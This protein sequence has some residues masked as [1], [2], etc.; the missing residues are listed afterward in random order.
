[1]SEDAAAKRRLG[2]G[3]SA[4]LGDEE[5]D[6]SELDKVRATKSVP[7]EFVEAGRFQPRRNF[8]AAE[9]AS[10]TASVREKGILQPILVRRHPD[11]ANKYEIVAGERRWRAAQAA[12]L[13]KIPVIIKEFS[14]RDA[15]EIAL[16][17]NLQREDLGPLEEATAYQR[18]MSEYSHTQEDTA[19]AVG[20]SRSHVANTLRLLELDDEVKQLLDKGD[21]TAGHAR[22][23]LKTTDQ[24]ATA[25]AVVAKGLNVRQTEHL[26]RR[27]KPRP[28][29]KPGR[30]KEDVP[31]AKDADTVAL[32]R[33]LT[34]LLGL[35][36]S[37]Q[38]Q[39]AGGSIT[40]H[41]QTLE[42]LDD[43]LHRLNQTPTGAG[44]SLAAGLHASNPAP[45]AA[46][47]GT[48][49][50]EE[51]VIATGV[52]DVSAEPSV[53]PTAQDDADAQDGGESVLVLDQE[54]LAMDGPTAEA[55]DATQGGEDV[56]VDVS[57]TEPV[58]DGD[59]EDVANVEPSSEASEEVKLES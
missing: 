27:A 4:L 8:D 29:A 24:V 5:Q 58:D 3:L 22:A 23:L 1:M 38:F 57:D 54:T 46:P 55:G 33:D 47:D 2:R 44:L 41:Y 35:R 30:V 28:A 36:V 20:K 26:C 48:L 12:Q 15:L 18:L 17:E 11:A 50:E 34:N 19:K 43:V 16:V 53:K 51:D 21:L 49:A 13:H 42:Q 10:L 37:I 9:M 59:A 56:T 31:Q 14:D 7:V 32:E 40:I 45:G 6:Y 39:G 52:P 25:K